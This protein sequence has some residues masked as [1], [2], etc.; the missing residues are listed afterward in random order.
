LFGIAQIG[1]A[2]S[3]YYFLPFEKKLAGAF[4][5]N[6]LLV[7]GGTGLLTMICLWIWRDKVGN[8]LNNPELSELLPLLGLYLFC[9]LPSVVLEIV[10]TVRK[11]HFAASAT[12]AL[13]DVFRALFLVVPVYFVADLHWLLYGAIAFA[14]LRLAATSIHAS[15]MFGISLHPEAPALRRQFG[16]A[17]PF[18]LSGLIEIMQTNFHLY[19]VSWSFDAA[20]FA[21]YAV[22]CLQIPLA[23][24]LMT[25]TSN[26]MMVN[27][28]ER[29]LSGDNASVA[30]I[31]LDSIRKLALVFLPL[32]GVLL[33]CADPLVVLLFTDTYA[34]SVP[35]FMLWTLSMVF[36]MLLTDGVLRVHAE[37]RFLIAQN[38]LRLALIAVLIRVFLQYFGLSGA[39]LVTLLATAIAKALALWRIRAVLQVGLGNLLPW[40]DLGNTLVLAC[41]ALLPALLMKAMLQAQP[42]L[43][44]VF[45]GAAYTFAYILLLQYWGPLQPDERRQISQWL[46]HPLRRL[47][48][49]L[50]P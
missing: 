42:L 50:K 17:L 43:Q 47:V 29:M 44:L 6:T 14:L 9:M 3:L 11:Q 8:L 35:I 32:A 28:R 10:M 39:I 34:A 25:S 48:P 15:Q 23:D 26:V 20:T 2:E 5:S 19:A 41:A 24:F 1:M 16:Y 38:L 49:V 31:W 4:V 13:S 7:L 21:V 40:R 45:T 33:V 27:M 22:G 12:Y 36:M 18:G 46:L 30:V 37:N